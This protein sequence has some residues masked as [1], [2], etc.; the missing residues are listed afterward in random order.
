MN[1]ISNPLDYL[2]TQARYYE[3]TKVANHILD[4]PDFAFWSGSSEEKSHHY[5]DGGLLQHTAEVV[6]LC[7]SNAKAFSPG[8]EI[9][10]RLLYLAA[11]YHDVG[12]L[13]DYG[14]FQELGNI[15]VWRATPHKTKIYHIPRSHAEWVKVADYERLPQYDTDEVSHAILAHH[16]LREW[17][18]PVSPRTR[19]S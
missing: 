17:G 12:K 9:D 1:F 3:V 10:Q 2:R 6:S 14:H 11:L 7:L 19:L 4:N 13:W 5:G 18:S 15:R 8:K 16:G